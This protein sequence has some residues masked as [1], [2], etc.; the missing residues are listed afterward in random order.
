MAVMRLDR[1]FS[2]QEILSRKEIR[3]VIKRGGITVNGIPASSPEQKVD[4]ERDAVALDGR[5]V[6]YRPYVYLMLNKPKGYVSSTDDKRNPTVLDLVPPQLWREGLFPAGRLDRDTVG[7]VLLTNDG[8]FAHEILSPKKHVPKTYLVRLDGPLCAD[9][10]ARLEAGVTLADGAVCK[11]ASVRVVEEGE[12]P[13]V[14]IVLREGKY[15][16]IKRMF[17]VIG[18]GV[19]WLKR[20]QIGGLA[21]DGQLPEGGCRE[22]LHKELDKILSL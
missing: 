18:L 6:S 11:G 13:L 19:N 20:T 2:S 16:Q 8:G 1:F 21:L 7:F 17:G 3:P 15:H 14:Q 4:P 9:G 12:E 22:I 5:E 10:I